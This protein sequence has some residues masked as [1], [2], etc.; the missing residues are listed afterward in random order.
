MHIFTIPN[1][2]EAPVYQLIHGGFLCA[3]GGGSRPQ[4][5]S[6]RSQSQRRTIVTM[7]CS[8]V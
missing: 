1:K 3:E 4:P 2:K 6:P 8:V 5:C 7:D